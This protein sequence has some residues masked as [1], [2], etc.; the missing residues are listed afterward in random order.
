VEKEL[1]ADKLYGF[2]LGQ[3]IANWTGL[4]TEM[5]K[6]GGDGKDGKAAGFY[7]RAAW[8][9]PDEPNLWS[10]EPSSISDT[11][12]FVFVD[13]NGVWGADDDTDIEY[14]YQHLMLQSPTGKLSGE[15]I[16]DG[17][18]RHIYT[19]QNTPFDDKENYLWVSNQRAQDLMVAGKVPPET[20]HPEYNEHYEMI[21]AQ[22][23]TEIFGL[24]APGRPDVAVDIAYL[25][26]R[27]TTRDEAALAA[28][29]YIRMHANAVLHPD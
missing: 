19:E 23:T 21:D 25:P 29:F 16:R 28:E 10:D 17:W 15:E 27:T 4:V 8:G 18:L 6:I 9:G 3:C 13:E 24:F 11:I 14:I 12:D 26:V 20:S 22:L 7:T 5:D 1:Y 2:W